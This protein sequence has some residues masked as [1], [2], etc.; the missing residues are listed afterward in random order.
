MELLRV[1]TDLCGEFHPG[2]SRFLSVRLAEKSCL[3]CV[4]SRLARSPFPPFSKRLLRSIIEIERRRIQGK[5]KRCNLFLQ[6][7]PSFFLFTFFSA[8]SCLLCL[9]GTSVVELLLRTHPKADAFHTEY[10]VL[11]PDNPHSQP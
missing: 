2:D 6:F 9:L 8:S 7:R 4:L 3:C 11:A 10:S 5:F 1:Y